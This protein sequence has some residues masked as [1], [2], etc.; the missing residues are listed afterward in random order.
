MCPL[1]FMGAVK[2]NTNVSYYLHRKEILAHT[3]THWKFRF[4]KLSVKASEGRMNVSRSNPITCDTAPNDARDEPLVCRTASLCLKSGLENTRL[5][6][7]LN[8]RKFSNERRSFN[9]S[10]LVQYEVVCC[11][12]L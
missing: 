2:L 1:I 9:P 12:F 10:K 7:T 3:G 11:W 5:G 4:A 6:L 8:T